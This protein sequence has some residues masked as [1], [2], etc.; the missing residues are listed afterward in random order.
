MRN[1]T[2]DSYI[3]DLRS[4]GKIPKIW[5]P[6][7]LRPFLEGLFSR[8]TLSVYPNNYSMS[9]DGLVKGDA[10]KRGMPAKYVRLGQARFVLKEEYNEK[11]SDSIKNETPY[12]LSSGYPTVKNPSRHGMTPG[13][14]SR[15][16]PFEKRANFFEKQLLEVF[17]TKEVLM[18]YAAMCVE[19]YR[20]NSDSFK[21]YHSLIDQQRKSGIA[22][23]ISDPSFLRHIYET[24][25]MWDM[26]YRGAK[27]VSFPEF[28]ES[29]NNLSSKIIRLA[30]YSMDL[31]DEN[32]EHELKPR[33]GE[34]FENL[35]VMQSK[36]RIVGVPKTMH[37]LL[38][39]LVMP[40]DGKFTLKFLFGYRVYRCS[41][42]WEARLFLDIFAAFSKFAHH[43]GLT[44]QDED[45]T[46][47]N[48]T[49]PKII[50]NAIIGYM[51]QQKRQTS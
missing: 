25:K 23:L 3:R 27:L 29:L 35:K 44:R 22:I 8:R 6:S 41:L 30:N 37:F 9:P 50:D 48:T 7:D 20:P 13:D 45:P 26:N 15:N 36:S 49:V 34:L 38:P 40:I 33:L 42:S 17:P 11:M 28:S 32:D 21:Y 14:G 2:L 5:S 43:V 16:H 31:L 10:V 4:Q 51:R 18:R 46:T 12:K 1:K 19:D 24:L 47:W 39:R